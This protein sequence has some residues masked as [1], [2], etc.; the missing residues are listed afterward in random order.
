MLTMVATTNDPP[1]DE[2]DAK[3]DAKPQPNDCSELAAWRFHVMIS[4][5]NDFRPR[6]HG[7]GQWTIVLDYSVVCHLGAGRESF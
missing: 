1:D 5:D 3:R 6:A 2:H 4:N 7:W